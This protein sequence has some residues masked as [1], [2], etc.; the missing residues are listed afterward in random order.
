MG[1]KQTIPGKGDAWY[2]Y[3]GDRY[4]ELPDGREWNFNTGK[5]RL[6]PILTAERGM[7]ELAK[8]KNP[9]V[10]RTYLNTLRAFADENGFI[11]EQVWDLNAPYGKTPGTTTG[12]VQPLNWAMGEYITLLASIAEGRA[13]GIPDVVAARYAK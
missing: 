8:T 7:Y 11:P 4:G 2:R 9:D 1:L 13:L 12:S 6:W 3:S 5:G 10:G